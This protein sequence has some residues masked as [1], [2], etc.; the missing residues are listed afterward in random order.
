MAGRDAAK[1]AHDE[2]T[3][4]MHCSRHAGFSDQVP[5]DM[6]GRDAAKDAQNDATGTERDAAHADL[7][8]QVSYDTAWRDAAKDVHVVAAGLECHAHQ[9]GLGDQVPFH[10]DDFDGDAWCGKESGSESARSDASSN[11]SST[12]NEVIMLRDMAVANYGANSMN[13]VG[14]SRSGTART[15]Q[16][17]GAAL[18]TRRTC[19]CELR[20]AAGA[21]ISSSLVSGPG[22]DMPPAKGTSYD[23]GVGRRSSPMASGRS[24]TPLGGTGFAA[25]FAEARRT[26]AR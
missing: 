8:G 21:T 16:V 2:A 4:I 22:W 19:A 23:R 14:C 15:P 5:Y 9:A 18:S 3:G 24:D 25:N 7:G 1:D 12:R 20:V 10:S 6:A 26:R 11:E 13:D 17:W